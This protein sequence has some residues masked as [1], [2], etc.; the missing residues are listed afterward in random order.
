M[1]KERPLRN[2]RI[3]HHILDPQRGGTITRDNGTRGL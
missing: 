3:P 2:A 1:R